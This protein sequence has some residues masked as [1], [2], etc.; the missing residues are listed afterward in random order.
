MRHGGL[1]AESQGIVGRFTMR[2]TSASSGEPRLVPQEEQQ[3]QQPDQPAVKKAAVGEITE[4]DGAGFAAA[5]A[6]GND[7]VH[8]QQAAAEVK[9]TQ[10]KAEA[11]HGALEGARAQQA[12]T[13]IDGHQVRHCALTPNNQAAARA[14]ARRHCCTNL[15]ALHGTWG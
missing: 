6:Q 11:H 12:E 2:S 1:A 4:G 10:I 3:L 14:T 5:A 15:M 13:T 8:A 9:P 7:N